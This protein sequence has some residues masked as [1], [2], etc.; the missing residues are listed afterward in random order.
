M[1]VFIIKV[2]TA[3]FRSAASLSGF[4]HNFTPLRLSGTFCVAGSWTLSLSFRCYSRDAIFVTEGV[5]I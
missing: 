3:E 5:L 4:L 1:Q 2:L